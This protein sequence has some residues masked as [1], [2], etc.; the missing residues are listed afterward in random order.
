MKLSAIFLLLA[1]SLTAADF[2]VTISLPDATAKEVLQTVTAWRTRQ[3]VD[4]KGTLKYPTNAALGESI[5]IDALRRIL[6]D[7]CE[8][9][10]AT[11]PS[12]VKTHVDA[13]ATAEAGVESAVN[14]AVVK[15]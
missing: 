8:F 3:V 7:Q 14:G 4:E 6:R 12:S 10:P 9:N 13:K 2:T 15:K 1:A 11:C 5:L